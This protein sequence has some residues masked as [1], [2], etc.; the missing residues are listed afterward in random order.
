MCGRQSIHQQQKKGLSPVDAGKIKRKYLIGYRKRII[1]SITILLL[2]VFLP[3]VLYG[4]ITDRNMLI[5]QLEINGFY[6]VNNLARNSETGVFSENVNFLRTPLS[7]ILEEHD[8]M[9]ATVYNTK[10]RTIWSDAK[11]M[12]KQPRMPADIKN[13][14]LTG[15]LVEA[16]KRVVKVGSLKMLDFYAPI[17]LKKGFFMTGDFEEETAPVQ[18]EIIGLARVGMSLQGPAKRTEQI[19]AAACF[20]T[21]VYVVLGIFAVYYI[22]D[23]ITKPV[24]DLSTGAHEIGKGNLQTRISVDSEDEIGELATSF[25]YM[26]D[27]LQQEMA[28]R[29][30]TEKERERLLKD[31]AD[32]NKEL[33][34]II[35]VASHDLRSPLVNIQGFSKEL[36]LSCKDIHKVLGEAGLNEKQRRTVDAIIDKDVPESLNYIQSSAYRMDILLKGLLRLSR[37]G[38]AAMKIE[39]LDM[40]DMLQK[41]LDSM[42]FQIQETRAQINVRSLPGCYGDTMLITQVFSNLVDNAV[43]YLDPR[44]NGVIK[45]SGRVE[46]DQSI[47]CIADNGIGIHADHKDKVFEI[48]HRLHPEGPVA[49][50][51]LGLSIIQRVLNRHNGQVWVESEPDVGSSFYVALPNRWPLPA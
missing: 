34:S 49:G 12:M 28:E 33:E 32:K 44:R 38:R 25:N 48:F 24:Q 30:K 10:G 5:N 29:K 9:W 17:Y 1:V 19:I 13:T 20:L 4:I 8:A 21:I 11:P 18:S 31:L 35:Y 22:Q 14:M 23:T 45:I 2:A 27:Q 16:Q 43:K 6:L 51:G 39:H 36:S 42:G 37:L 7:A 50:E 41:I 15:D 26:A 46:G 40:N 3:L 47:Y